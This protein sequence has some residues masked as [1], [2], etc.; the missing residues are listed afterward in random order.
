M[1]LA[2]E[3]VLSVAMIGVTGFFILFMLGSEWFQLLGSSPAFRVLWAVLLLAL[4]TFFQASWRPSEQWRRR[5]GWGRWSMIFLA[6]IAFLIA[7]AIGF[8]ATP[9]VLAFS[10]A[11]LAFVVAVAALMVVQ[12]LLM[13]RWALRHRSPVV[14]SW[15]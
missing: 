2:R 6:G 11:E 12:G 5:V 4:Q 15:A 10:L 13:L 9:L 8:A 1:A 3:R 7:G 14:V